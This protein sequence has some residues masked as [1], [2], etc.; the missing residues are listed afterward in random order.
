MGDGTTR[1]S[2][3]TAAQT[4][5][6]DAAIIQR[7]LRLPEVLSALGPLLRAIRSKPATAVHAEAK[8]LALVAG[9][10]EA[11]PVPGCSD[12]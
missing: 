11:G 5:M 7:R 2:P 10:P 12:V 9:F 3:A 6:A 4:T 8:N 1:T